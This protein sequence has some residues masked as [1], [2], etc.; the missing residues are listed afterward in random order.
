M[1][2]LANIPYSVFPWMKYSVKFALQKSQCFSF[3]FSFMVSPVPEQCRSLVALTLLT[4]L[5]S[6]RTR[7]RS[8]DRLAVSECVVAAL[9]QCGV[10]LG[11]C[12]FCHLEPLRVC[13]EQSTIMLGK[14]Q[15]ETV[16]KR[17]RCPCCSSAMELFAPRHAHVEVHIAEASRVYPPFGFFKR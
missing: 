2:M 4:R 7:L 13:L 10:G 16:L 6:T 15:Q 14:F 3:G 1:H 8:A 17:S 9:N 12:C 11:H 5:A